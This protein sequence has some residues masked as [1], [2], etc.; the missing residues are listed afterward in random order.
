MRIN[1][2]RFFILLGVSAA[3]V[4]LACIVGLWCAYSGWLPGADR[5]LEGRH[6]HPFSRYFV[7]FMHICAK[8]LVLGIIAI[9]IALAL[10]LWAR[11]TGGW[12]RFTPRFVFLVAMTALLL[13]L[14]LRI[15]FAL[16]PG[17]IPRL[18]DPLLIG[19]PSNDDFYWVLLARTTGKLA[20]ESVS[21]ELGWT[22]DK[23]APDNPI[24]LGP[25]ARQALARSGPAIYFYGDSFVHGMP[26]NTKTLPTMVSEK[27][28]NNV[29]N[30]G[31]MG[32]GVDQMYLKARAMGL[33]P[34]GSEVWVGILTWDLDRTYQNYTSGQKPRFTLVDG[35]LVL[36]NVPITR[37]NQE[38]VRDY[39]MPFRSWLW[40]A[41]KR[42]FE[43]RFG[44]EMEG[45]VKEEKIALNRAVL[46]KWSAW[47]REANIPL[48]VVLFHT[49]RDLAWESWRTTA[50]KNFSKD[51]DLPLFDTAEILA[52]YLNQPGAS[53]DDLFQSGD[54]HHTDHAYDMISDWLATNWAQ[55]VV[56]PE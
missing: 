1:F 10:R 32:Y 19:E 44:L 12:R 52:P 29:I 16:P 35:A 14:V 9:A 5:F 23:P 25:E 55:S 33:P 46:E 3:G 37:S 36:T 22:Q 2:T 4:F 42:R 45:P 56:A 21:P 38:F 39:K 43:L 54:F 20:R 27:S 7:N 51:L 18:Q 28:G 41:C 49:S 34:P 47:C 6:I 53:Y 50:V 40:Q 8:A 26:Y 15:T 13:E 11:K 31:V 48:K 30:L 24:G 17:T